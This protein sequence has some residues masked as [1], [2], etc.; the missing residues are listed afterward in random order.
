MPR[1]R[2]DQRGQAALELIAVLPALV[3]AALLGWQL[4][5]RRVRVDGGERGGA[6]RPARPEVG[7]PAR[8]AALAALPAATPGR[9]RVD[10]DAR[11]G[12]RPRRRAGRP[13]LPASRRASPPRRPRVR[14]RPRQAGQAAVELLAAIPILVLVGLLA[15]QLVG[16]L[17]AGF[18]AE[19][20]VRLEALNAA[21]AAG[22]TAL[23][24]DRARPGPA[25]GRRRAAGARAAA[26]RVP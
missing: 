17:A 14:E 19:Q 10:A 3:L 24:S 4:A 1:R 25:P 23:V 13:A 22:G 20:R 5:G 8:A 11:R 21:G 2:R 12:A 7:A 15:W 16:V 6:S 26:I 18:R 9:R